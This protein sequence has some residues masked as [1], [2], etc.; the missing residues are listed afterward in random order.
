MQ[1]LSSLIDI[2]RS[3]LVKVFRYAAVS[4]ITV[5]I[6]TLLLWLFLRADIKPVIAT[7]MS[8]V[9]ATI[10]NYLLNRYWVWNKTSS[11]S[12]KREIVPFC[13][14]ALLGLALSTLLVAIAD[15]FTDATLVFLIVNICAFG[16]VWLMKFFVLEQ[17]LFG[18][19]T[20]GEVT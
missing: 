11:N 16:I 9:L 7:V 15:Q 14:L 19:T 17:Y 12:V 1:S 13:L 18:D 5:P 3:D 6:G 2:V 4:L 8:F 20:D 10:P